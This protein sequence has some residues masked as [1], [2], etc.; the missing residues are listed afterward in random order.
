MQRLALIWVVAGG[1][2][3]AAVAEEPRPGTGREVTI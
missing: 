1:M 3:A 2:L